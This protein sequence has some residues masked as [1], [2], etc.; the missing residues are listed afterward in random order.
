MF[1]LLKGY[2]QHFIIMFITWILLFSSIEQESVSQ[3]NQSAMETMY[4]YMNEDLAGATTIWWQCLLQACSFTMAYFGECHS[5]SHFL[6]KVG[7]DGKVSW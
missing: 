6:K 3:R 7:K 5:Q 1:V 2:V 4:I